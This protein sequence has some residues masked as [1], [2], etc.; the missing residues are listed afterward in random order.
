MQVNITY[1]GNESIFYDTSKL[2]IDEDGFKI[3]FDYLDE[4]GNVCTT[5]RFCKELPDKITIL[6]RKEL[7]NE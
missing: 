2:S 5:T 3:T 1:N 4:Q 6:N 7:K